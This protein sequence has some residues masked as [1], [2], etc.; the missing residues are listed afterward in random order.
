MSKLSSWQAYWYICS[1]G[2]IFVHGM[3]AVHGL[4]H[5]CRILDRE[6]VGERI[7][8]DAREPL[9][10]VERRRIAPLEDHAIVGSEIR[11]LD[12]QRIAVPVTAR[13]PEPLME[14]RCRGAGA[15]RAG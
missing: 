12:H 1:A 11:R 7:G 5:V 4:V 13:V 9:R 6:L 10:D 8:V 14:I 3:R 15:R 2:S